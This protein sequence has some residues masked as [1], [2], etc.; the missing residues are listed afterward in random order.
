MMDEWWMMHGGCRIPG[1]IPGQPGQLWGGKHRH[2]T[3][4]GPSFPH[5]SLGE[6]GSPGNAPAAGSSF[7]RAQIP[8]FGT[9]V[10]RSAH[11]PAPLLCTIPVISSGAVLIVLPKLGSGQILH[12]I[13][14]L[15]FLFYLILFV[16]PR[17][18]PL[19]LPK[20]KKKRGKKRKKQK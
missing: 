3:H 19:G 20:K 13:P 10:P 14:F 2:Q 16:F 15:K 12:S 17:F 1:R 4:Q 11:P 8:N 6:S 5:P 9:F 7:G 18:T